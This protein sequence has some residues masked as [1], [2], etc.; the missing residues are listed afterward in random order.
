MI[1]YLATRKLPNQWPDTET[2]GTDPGFVH[3]VNTRIKISLK[4]FCQPMYFKYFCQWELIF[5]INHG[6]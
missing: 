3:P 6:I 1:P 2:L 5:N 4:C